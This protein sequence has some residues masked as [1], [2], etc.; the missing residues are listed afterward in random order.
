VLRRKL[1]RRPHPSTV[2][3]RRCSRTGR[4][5]GGGG[6]SDQTN[7]KDRDL[8]KRG[9]RHCSEPKSRP[10]PIRENPFIDLTV[11]PAA[12]PERE[13]HKRLED[14][15]NGTGRSPP[16]LIRGWARRVVS[17]LQGDAS[18]KRSHAW[19]KTF[20]RGAAYG[21]SPGIL[22]YHCSKQQRRSRDCPTFSS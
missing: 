7:S 13:S 18:L 4:T 14:N 12:K 6:N 19:R 3:P 21:R 8:G 11:S 2:I 15:C 1:K 22:K 16:D 9:E 5:S 17:H 20:V 10:L